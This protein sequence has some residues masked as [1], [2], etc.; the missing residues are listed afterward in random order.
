M[1][2]AST[3]KIIYLPNSLG[4]YL[5]NRKPCYRSSLMGT[6]LLI[7]KWYFRNI[8]KHAINNI[9][10]TSAARKGAKLNKNLHSIGTRAHIHIYFWNHALLSYSTLYISPISNS[11]WSHTVISL[12]F[13]LIV[14]LESIYMHIVTQHSKGQNCLPLKYHAWCPWDMQ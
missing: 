8:T 11:V 2:F 4:R 7:A 5:F 3:G 12:T 10:R 6:N 14:K 1:I 13:F 9:W